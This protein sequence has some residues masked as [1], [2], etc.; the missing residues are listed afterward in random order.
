MIINMNLTPYMCSPDRL[1]EVKVY[2]EAVDAA[3]V[4]AKL[5]GPF[6]ATCPEC[7]VDFTCMDDVIED[8]GHIIV[9]LT[10]DTFAVV[11][12]CEGYFVVDPNLV[13]IDSP[14][15]LGPDDHYGLITPDGASAGTPGAPTIVTSKAEIENELG[16][17]ED[18]DQLLLSA[19]LARPN[20]DILNIVQAA[21]EL[22]GSLYDRLS[23][24][25]NEI[26]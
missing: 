3:I 8:E 6:T 15:W 12:A 26:S 21:A 23:K 4:G 10:S 19:I 7:D 20:G 18:R 16:N 24:A 5:E 14:M 17:D 22:P 11:V 25:Y 9:S 1:P 2:A 13:G